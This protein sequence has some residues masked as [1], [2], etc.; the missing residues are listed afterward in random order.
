M[1]SD[2]EQPFFRSFLDSGGVVAHLLILELSIVSQFNLQYF[3]GVQCGVR[4]FLL[5]E[6][7]SLFSDLGVLYH[8]LGHREPLTFFGVVQHFFIMPFYMEYSII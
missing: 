7:L 8:I 1:V 2:F 6:H 5:L 3:Q 4:L